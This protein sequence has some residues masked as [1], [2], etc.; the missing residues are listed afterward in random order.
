MK[1]K[2]CFYENLTDLCVIA[3]NEVRQNT[4]SSADENLQ[5]RSRLPGG[6]EHVGRPGSASAADWSLVQ[7]AYS[8]GDEE[9]VKSAGFTKAIHFDQFFLLLL[10][11][12]SFL[13][14]S[15][16]FSPL[17]TRETQRLC[18]Y[19]LG[20]TFFLLF[21]RLVV[22]K[23]P[24]WMH[25]DEI[26]KVFIWIIRLALRGRWNRQVWWCRG[27]VIGWPFCRIP[28]RWWESREPSVRSLPLRYPV[29]TNPP[30]KNENIAPW[31]L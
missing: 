18:A 12:N 22:V 1:K 29:W 14:G 15:N 2:F 30:A 9:A 11:W 7:D 3:E 27:S 19:F 23:F 21:R 6:H 20:T 26:S 4:A 24:L 13:T 5:E 8:F 28:R 25:W 10:L 16:D 31:S 17:F